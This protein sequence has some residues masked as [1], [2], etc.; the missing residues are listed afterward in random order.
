MRPA[1]LSTEGE[2]VSAIEVIP[3]TVVLSP[4]QP[5]TFDVRL[6][7]A[8]GW[9]INAN[10]ASPSHLVPTTV[11]LTS[12]GAVHIDQVTY[13]AGKPLA[14]GNLDDRLLVYD[15]TVVLSVQASL[16]PQATPDDMTIVLR[17]SYQACDNQRC[18]APTQ[19]EVRVPI[20]V[21]KD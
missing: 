15:G 4:G 6:R 18:L 3:A 1:P 8:D 7:V 16:T 11:T 13:P 9:H 17:L 5:T 21:A 14:M 12:N 10:P 20:R 2:P 19:R